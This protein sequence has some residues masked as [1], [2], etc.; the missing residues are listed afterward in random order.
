MCTECVQGCARAA[1]AAREVASPNQIASCATNEHGHVRAFAT[2]AEVEQ[3]EPVAV[4]EAWVVFEL[5]GT[6]KHRQRQARW[7]REHHQVR[8]LC[9]H[10]VAVALEVAGRF[11]RARL[12]RREP[13]WE[14][15]RR[16]GAVAQ[17]E[18]VERGQPAVVGEGA[19]G[20][21]GDAW[22]LRGER[23]A[24]RLAEHLAVPLPDFAARSSSRSSCSNP[25]ICG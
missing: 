14:W 8:L 2:V 7:V 11:R 18:H 15:R 3:H 25:S 19:G 10:V 20:V 6:D 22:L 5:A 23:P 17:T 21:D 24:E 16:D 13:R 12:G 9:H 1:G 4:E